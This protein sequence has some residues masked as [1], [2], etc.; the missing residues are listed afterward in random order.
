MRSFP[1]RMVGVVCL[2]LTVGAAHAKTPGQ[3]CS[4]RT[5]VATGTKILRIMK[6][7]ANATKAG[8]AVD[9]ACLAKIGTGDF[10]NYINKVTAGYCAFDDLAVYDGLYTTTLDELVAAIVDAA[11]GQKCASLKQSA[12]SKKALGAL[13]CY[14]NAKKRD[15]PLDPQCL[16]KAQEKFAA[17]IAKA[18]RV[19]GC[20]TPGGEI[21]IGALVDDFVDAAV[22]QL[23]S[24]AYSLTDNGDGTITDSF[25]GLMWAK[26]SYD[27][28]IHSI[29]VH[30]SYSGFSPFENPDGGLFAVYLAGLN[31]PPC[32]AGH[33]DWRLPTIDELTG[34]HIDPFNYCQKGYSPPCVPPEFDT[35]CVPGCSVLT[36][37]CSG[38]D[39]VYWSSS[40][41]LDRSD[42]VWGAA[43]SP[44]VGA[45]LQAPMPKSSNLAYA[46][47]VRSIP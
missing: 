28:T 18:D 46:R 25:N 35:N 39:R 8:M 36:C 15:M 20:D 10:I 1:I 43:Y 5:M 2:V 44:Y 37:S 16:T 23:R 41:W 13:K 38:W 47:A 29:D 6:C 30:Y 3:A 24:E 19:D 27:G 31:T 4:A 9:P 11:P 17:G 26:N 7:H 34:I 12:A 32:F 14:A 21:E 45:T 33:C 42:Y 40:Q 22:A